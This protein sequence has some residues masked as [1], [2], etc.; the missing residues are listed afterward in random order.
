MESNTKKQP[1]VLVVD[2]D[3]SLRL[4]IKAALKKSDLDVREAENGRVALEVLQDLEPDLILMDVM[5][6]EMD[7]FETCMAI[8]QFP[9]RE[10][11]PI[12][13][14]TGMD[15]VESTKRAFEAGAT[16]FISKP[17]NWVMLAYRAQ[18]MLRASLA[19]NE[20]RQSQNRLAKTQEIALLGNW[21]I[22]LSTHEFSCPP[23][24][25][26]LLGLNDSS[27]QINYNRFFD[28]IHP[29]E[30]D[31][32]IQTI[33]EAIKNKESYNLRYQIIKHDGEQI[34][35]ANHGEIITDKSGRPKIMLGTVQDVSKI[36]KAEEKIR[37]LAF[38]DSL[39][40]LANRLL[41]MDRLEMALAT[42]KRYNQCMALLF[43]DIDRFKRINDTLGHHVGDML[44]KKVAERISKCVRKTDATSRMLPENDNIVARIGGDE[45]NIMLTNISKPEDAALVARRIIKSIPEKV[46]LEDK[47]EVSVTSS[48]GISI[49]PSDGDDADTLLMRADTAMYHVK[50]KGRNDFEF[51]KESLNA[52]TLERFNL[53]NDLLSSLERGDFELY[54]QPQL[55]LQTM[56][57][58]GCEALIRW[59][60]Y[61][62]GMIPPDK[63]IP[64][65]EETG[66]IFAINKWVIHAAC[67]QNKKWQ[68][69]GLP[70]INVAVN[71][72]GHNFSRQNIIATIGDALTE[73]NLNPENLEVEITES[74]LM[75]EEDTADTL[76]MIKDLHLRLAIDDFGTGYSSLS[77]LTS[78][79]IDTIKIDRSFVMSCMS[80]RKNT[81]IIK[82]IVAMGHSLE[83]KIVAE[84]IE[85][86]EQLE[87]LQGYGCDE[88]QGFL[89]SPPVP[90]NQFEELLKKGKF[91]TWTS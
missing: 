17:I 7:G 68:E 49:F 9:D 18:Y 45:F 85:T 51:Y 70:K 31:R 84:G 15:D 14:V 60:H 21:E 24:T 88:G 55:N 39:T 56:E 83:L 11:I 44:L 67:R 16:D 81:V 78:F 41:F 19:S 50:D 59:N 76:Q 63:F 26:Q 37:T 1:I 35:I 47:Y 6:P 58:V 8:R 23:K 80:Q 79:P 28:T 89:F 13:M 72:S 32:V 25:C 42:S 43:L 10:H 40:G 86:K 66:Q 12:L 4:S 77:Y 20:L 57:I 64:L 33:D 38:Y 46:T 69:A 3:L 87:L 5:M 71:L 75:Q 82:A 53:E 61:K 73:S 22:N 52:S 2:D 36:T 48:I 74:I 27:A 65:A 30:K 90:A 54:F 91:D 29:S 34:Y 62:L